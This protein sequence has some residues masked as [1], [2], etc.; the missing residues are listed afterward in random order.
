VKFP[1][2]H[3]LPDGSKLSNL[4]AEAGGCSPTPI[5]APRL[6]PPQHPAHPAGPP[7]RFLRAHGPEFRDNTKQTSSAA[8][9]TTKASP[10]TFPI[11]A[12]ARS[13]PHRTLPGTRPPRRQSHLRRFPHSHHNVVLEDGDESISRA[14]KY[15]HGHGRS[16][17]PN[18]FVWNVNL[19]VQDY[20][21]KAGGFIEGAD[22]KQ[23]YVVMSSGE[24]PLRFQQE[25][26]RQ[27]R[28]RLPPRVPATLSSFPKFRPS[29]ASSTRPPTSP[30]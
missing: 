2:T 7:R 5:C 18:A 27:R 19:S 20:I 14:A 17:L 25:Y 21:N 28:R 24:V 30:C 15:R 3:V 22:K 12:S 10:R 8:A 29:A 4:L 1:G 6:H 16:Q 23:I 11:S 9:T 26:L 13:P